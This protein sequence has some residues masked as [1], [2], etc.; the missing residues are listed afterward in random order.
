MVLSTHLVIGGVLGRALSVS[1]ALAFA[2]G[3]VS[4]FILDALP[5]WDYQLGSTRDGATALD[6]NMDL[7]SR[8]FAFD[9]IKIGSDLAIGI[10]VLL[11]TG[12]LFRWPLGSSMFWGALGGILP[13][14]CQFLYF[15]LRWPSLRALQ[16]FHLWAHASRRLND[17]RI[18]GPL[19]QVA[20]VLVVILLAGGLL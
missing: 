8:S 19:L 20:L 10:V 15:K 5:H 7:S 6:R 4:H 2:A 11:A 1:P 16:R 17:W 14:F 12:Y 18:F 13:D 3:V 9:L